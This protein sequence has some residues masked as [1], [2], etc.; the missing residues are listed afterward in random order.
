MDRQLDR[1]RR[2][3]WMQEGEWDAWME[4]WTAEQTGGRKEIWRD[5]EMDGREKEC[6]CRTEEKSPAFD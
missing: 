3:G 6:R 1:G 5:G 2:D 4:G